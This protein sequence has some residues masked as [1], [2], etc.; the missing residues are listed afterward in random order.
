MSLR[1][2]DAAKAMSSKKGDKIRVPRILSRWRVSVYECEIRSAGALSVGRY[3][4][5]EYGRFNDRMLEEK[6][7]P[8]ISSYLA[9]GYNYP[10][11]VTEHRLEKESTVTF[12]KLKPKKKE[13]ME[14]SKRTADRPKTNV[15]IIYARGNYRI[16]IV[17]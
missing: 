3:V 12:H 2:K 17:E 10:F 11:L 7:M 14:F 9:A 4:L 13:D 16:L 5:G 15:A 1:F 6:I 8:R